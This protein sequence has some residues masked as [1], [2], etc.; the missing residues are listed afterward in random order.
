MVEL[1][2]SVVLGLLEEDDLT[3][4]AVETTS[5]HDLLIDCSRRQYG[6]QFLQVQPHT[7]ALQDILYLHLLRQ[8][9]GLLIDHSKQVILGSSQH[10]ESV[11]VDEFD[12]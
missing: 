3:L 11:L 1:E 7:L 4:A 10:E 12:C 9:I 6:R 2:A 5:N 8:H